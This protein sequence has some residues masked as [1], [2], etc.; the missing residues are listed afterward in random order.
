MATTLAQLAIGFLA[1]ALAVVTVHQGL[2]YL[3]A[4]A[5]LSPATPWSTKPVG[6]LGVPTIVNSMFWGGLW[7]FAYA[8]L[9]DY[10]PSEVTWVRGLVFG[11]M[12]AV[13]GNFV[14]VP[15]IKGNPLFLSFDV[16][17][18]LV[19]LTILSGFGIATA[20]FYEALAA[21]THR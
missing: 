14:L 9:R 5:G 8:L 7:G 17:R 12:I 2:V 16:K 6:L 20:L 10:L 4:R 1:A 15:L 13:A 3:F 19:V 21:L 11:L 18:M